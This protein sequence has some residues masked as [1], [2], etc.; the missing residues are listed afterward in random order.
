M[1]A[2]ADVH[3]SRTAVASN[4][5]LPDWATKVPAAMAAVLT[6]A[7]PILAFLASA[8]GGFERMLR[9][10]RELTIASS[11]CVGLGFVLVLVGF[12]V[13]TSTSPKRN[14][15][16]ARV[17]AVASVVIVLGIGGILWAAGRSAGLREEP[18]I[19]AGFGLDPALHLAATVRASGLQA[20]ERVNVQVSGFRP[21][22]T[23]EQIYVSVTGP[24]RT[25][26]IELPIS[27]PLTP[28]Y[29]DHV[30]IAVWH[31]GATEPNCTEAESGAASG[32][33]CA[34]LALARPVPS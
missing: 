15:Y 14:A 31:V 13:L 20:D 8:G 29:F 10:D 6:L 21:D 4:A 34:R 1:A 16:A 32:V 22:A 28:G 26:A 2:V 24:D 23:K 7:S 27:I 30:Q 17:F 3:M 33:A 19:S 11:I 18:S 12:F 9:N 5:E 25:G